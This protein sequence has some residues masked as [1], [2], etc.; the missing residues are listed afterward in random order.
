[1]KKLFHLAIIG[2]MV[3][4]VTS[5]SKSA[6]DLLPNQEANATQ[7]GN[8]T[9]EKQ[10]GQTAKVGD[11]VTVGNPNI[12]PEVAFDGP[13]AIYPIINQPHNMFLGTA[14]HSTLHSGNGSEVVFYV[15]V[16]PS[17]ILPTTTGELTLRESNNG[18][19]IKNFNLIS[20]QDAANYGIEVPDDLANKTYYFAIVNIDVFADYADKYISLHADFDANTLSVGSFGAKMGKALIYTP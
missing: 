10:N 5:C 6:S 7:K 19:F 9:T 11:P 17:Y 4:S 14:K 2:L 15:L 12:A 1:M 3:L 8:A 13:A 20:Y 18:A 16:D